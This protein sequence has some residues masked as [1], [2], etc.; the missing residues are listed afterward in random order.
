MS[1]AFVTDPDN[2]E[3]TEAD[4]ARARPFA[5]VFP[6]IAR[7]LGGRPKAATPKVH[8]GFRIAADIAARIK[9]GGPGAS[10]RVE[11]ILRHAME[12]GRL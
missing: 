5:E 9:A 1:D 7:N 11:A 10:G 6:H 3:L 4:F 2:P 8:V 12:E